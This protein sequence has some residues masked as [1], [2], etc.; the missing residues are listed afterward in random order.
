MGIVTAF[1][2]I[3]YVCLHFHA[4]GHCHALVYSFI[5]M[6]HSYYGKMKYSTLL[7]KVKYNILIKLKGLVLRNYIQTQTMPCHNCHNCH[8]CHLPLVLLHY[9]NDQKKPKKQQWFVIILVLLVL[10]WNLLPRSHLPKYRHISSFCLNC[11][12][13]AVLQCSVLLCF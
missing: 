13:V 8:M 1:R 3:Y 11:C 4:M 7:T 2:L 10:L 9:K 6:F 5:T 12:S